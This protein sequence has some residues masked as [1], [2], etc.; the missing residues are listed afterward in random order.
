MNTDPYFGD[1]LDHSLLDRE[2]EAS[3]ADRIQAGGPDAEVAVDTLVRHNLRLAYHMAGAWPAHV[4]M[5]DLYSAACEGLHKAARAY[6]TGRNARFSTF[7]AL[8]IRQALARETAAHA[9]GLIRVPSYLGPLLATI[10]RVE[11]EAEARGQSLTPTELLD[12]VGDSAVGRA[13]AEY[14]I[15]VHHRTR[16]TLPSSHADEGQPSS[17]QHAM[18]QETIATVLAAV[19]ALPATYRYVVQHR[20]GL[21]G[22]P[23]ET[24]RT[25]AKAL[26]MTPERVRQLQ[27]VAL[28]MLRAVLESD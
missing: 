5:E 9:Q 2:E 3:L 25:V 17:L 15:A 20:F 1:Q 27:G 7:A 19:E 6:Q 21:D 16:D 18:Q 12:Q 26:D 22:R 24:L 10:R 28:R 13:A 14:A 23:I 11:D 8:V 4:P